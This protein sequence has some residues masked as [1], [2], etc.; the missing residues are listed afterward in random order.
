MI[1]KDLP[2]FARLS[3]I[4]DESL[5]KA[6]LI[7]NYKYESLAKVWLIIKMIDLPG[8]ARLFYYL[9]LFCQS[10][11]DFFNFGLNWKT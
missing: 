1:F 8:L 9:L 6:W 7:K 2:D 4:L 3:Y 10:L 5:A 11:A